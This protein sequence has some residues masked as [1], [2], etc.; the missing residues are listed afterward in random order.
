VGKTTLLCL[1]ATVLPNVP[2]PHFADYPPAAPLV[3]PP[4]SPRLKTKEARLFQTQLRNWAA[5]GPN[6]SGHFSLAHWG[7]GTGCL[8]MAVVDLTSGAVFM[9][10]GNVLPGCLMPREDKDGKL[11]RVDARVDSS[12][13][14]VY[15]CF[16]DWPCGDAEYHRVSYSWTG[17]G[18][19]LVGRTC[20]PMRKPAE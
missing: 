19:R 5:E 6:F 10:P 8:R 15:Q 12:L 1:V 4:A 16:A 17:A 18:I 7:C 14:H 20:V 13:F 9:V 3:G 2:G 11:E